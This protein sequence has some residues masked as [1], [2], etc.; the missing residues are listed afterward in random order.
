MNGKD[1]GTLYLVATPIGNLAD[2][3]YRA[4]ETLRSVDLIAAEDTRHSR[5]LL[6][7]YGVAAPVTSYHEH[8]KYEKA[9]VLVG[10]L[11]EGLD[12]ALITDAGTPAISDPGEVLVGICRQEGIKVTSLPGPSAVITAISLSGLPSRSFAF[13]GFLPADNTERKSVLE[14]LRGEQRT[15]VLYEAPHRLKKTLELLLDT[16]G[17]RR[18]CVCRELTKIHEETP[19]MLLSE[20]VA[21]FAEQ[22]PRGEFVLVVE[23]ADPEKTAEESRSLWQELSLS[24]HLQQYLDKGLD[25]REAMKKM[26]AD[27]GCSRRDIYNGLLEEEK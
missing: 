15:I 1:K 13:E 22:P 20:A 9:E 6:D 26:A 27:R 12:I 2:I 24:E 25:K 17:D 18:I 10:K 5:I 16:L 11:K 14:R 3:T 7:H 23:G 8:N 4:V 21:A 19:L